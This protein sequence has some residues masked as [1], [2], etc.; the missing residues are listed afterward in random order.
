MAG[1]VESKT[2]AP[3]AAD[4]T[5]R[6][7]RIPESSFP[8]SPDRSSRSTETKANT[9]SPAINATTPPRLMLMQTPN[10]KKKKRYS[11]IPRVTHRSRPQQAKAMAKSAPSPNN[12]ARWF[13]LA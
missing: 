13:L 4:A 8:R 2:K 9:T 6:M 11:R 10:P 3:A 5:K 1:F 7:I 12:Q